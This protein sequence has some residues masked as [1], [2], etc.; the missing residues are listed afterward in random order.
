M[1]Y[2][3]GG[4]SSA[5][6]AS[7][8]ALPADPEVP[9]HMQALARA[10]AVRRARFEMRKQMKAVGHTEARKI[11]AELIANPPWW[12][13]TLR[14]GDLLSAIPKVGPSAMLRLFTMFNAGA[15]NT[16]SRFNELG[17]LTDRQRELL[18]AAISPEDD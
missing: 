1:T 6:D 10:N 4:G 13:K 5:Q 7:P 16:I 17:S 11:A 3:H 12:A 8:S 2:D 15:P 14:L 9:Q 18:I